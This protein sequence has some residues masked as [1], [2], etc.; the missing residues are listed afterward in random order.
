MCTMYY[1]IKL[2]LTYH[3]MKLLSPV[4][5]LVILDNSNFVMKFF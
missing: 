3:Y 1:S 2:G 4:D 5:N